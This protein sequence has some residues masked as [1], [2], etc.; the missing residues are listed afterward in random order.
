MKSKFL[1]IIFLLSAVCNYSYSQQDVNGWFWING[2]PTGNTL[3]WVKIV[4]AANI[5]AVGDFG[6]FMKSTDGGDTWS[7]NS[8]VGSPDNSSTGGGSAA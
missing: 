4:D 5:Y 6:T 2:Q 3:R 8:Q 7:V 1:S